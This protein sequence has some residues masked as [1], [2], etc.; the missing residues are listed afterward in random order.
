MSRVLITGAS[1]FIGRNLAEAMALN[2]EVVAMSRRPTDV[3]G[4]ASVCGDF[5]SPDGLRLLDRYGADVVIHLAAVTGGCAESDGIRV[6]VLGTHG[7]IRYWMDR[8][9]RKFVLA[10][11]IAAVGMQN[12]RFRPLQVPVPDEHPCFDRD[13]YGLSKYLMEEVARYLVRQ[14]DD[15]DIIALRFA[16]ILP[17]D[18]VPVPRKPGPVYPWALGS[19]TLM[20]VSDAVRC[21]TLAADAAHKPGIRI[22]NAVGTEACVE[23]SVPD[24]LR[25]WWGADADALD[26]SWYERAGHERDAVYDARRVAAELG[27]VPARR[28]LLN[29]SE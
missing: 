14:N 21:L 12:V 19:V 20:Y 18:A 10:S 15:L 17:E 16:S 6:N 2:H 29:G 25:A 4:V 24:V 22:M 1:G 7:L 3:N 27:F 8:G 13:G 9:C 11:S 26:L 23:P 28:V 5:A